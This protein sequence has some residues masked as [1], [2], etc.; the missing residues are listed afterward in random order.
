MQEEKRV[1]VRETAVCS[2][3]HLLGK[4][5]LSAISKIPFREQHDL[6][7]LFLVDSKKDLSN[8]SYFQTSLITKI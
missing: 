5:V 1:L 6:Q 7:K 2:L 3:L 4:I 8:E